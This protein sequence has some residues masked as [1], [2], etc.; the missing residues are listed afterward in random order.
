MS[1]RA[2]PTAEDTEL[3]AP[4]DGDNDYDAADDVADVY[5]AGEAN[6]FNKEG[7]PALPFRTDDWKGITEGAKY[8]IGK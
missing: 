8:T 5:D 4:F 1:E 3:D 2:N 7:F 6:L